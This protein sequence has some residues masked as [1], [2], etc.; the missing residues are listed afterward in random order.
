MFYSLEGY[1]RGHFITLCPMEGHLKGHFSMFFLLKLYPRG[2]FRAASEEIVIFCAAQYNRTKKN[3]KVEGMAPFR[4]GSSG[5][6][7][8]CLKHDNQKCN[9]P[10]EKGVEIFQF[11]KN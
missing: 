9:G 8:A 5:L 10:Q 4:K 3:Q 7:F 6:R 2:H 1:L 11:M